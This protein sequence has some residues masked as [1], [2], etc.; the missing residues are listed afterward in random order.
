ML[1]DKKVEGS[2]STLL[3]SSLLLLLGQHVYETNVPSITRSMTLFLTPRDARI[4][5]FY[6]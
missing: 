5:N 6:R 1:R 2:L 4:A 3:A